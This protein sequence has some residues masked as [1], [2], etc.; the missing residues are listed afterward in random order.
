MYITLLGLINTFLC[1]MIGV[2][3]MRQ[4]LL[5][6]KVVLYNTPLVINFYIIIFYFDIKIGT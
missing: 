4:L 5:Q 6:Y 1:I 3:N 2:P